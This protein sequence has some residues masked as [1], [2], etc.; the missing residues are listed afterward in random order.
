MVNFYKR[1]KS[2]LAR[3]LK[4]TVLILIV[5]WAWYVYN[6]NKVVDVKKVSQDNKEVKVFTVPD[7]LGSTEI[8]H[9]LKEEGLIKSP[10]TFQFYVWKEGIDSKLKAGEYYLSGE[11][12][13]KEIAQILTKGE[14]KTGEITLTF[15]EGWNVNEIGKYLESKGLATQDEFLDKVQQKEGWWDDYEFLRQ[16]PKDVD[17]EGYLFPD[18]YR[19]YSD[20]KV[21][22]IIRKM[23]DN[24]EVKLTQEVYQA[25]KNQGKS[26]HEIV[27]LASILEKEVSTDQDRRIVAGIFHKRLNI[28]MG[29]Q[30]DATVNYATGK[31]VTRP[32]FGDLETESPYNTYKYRGLPPGPISNPSISSIMAAIN[33]EQND[34]LY[35]LTT[36]EGEVI[37]SKTFDEHVA[38]KNKYY[39]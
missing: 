30:S 14:G 2:R 12:D 15:I 25:I 19:V 38:A 23:V 27:T 33:L 9:K 21:E 11:L 3:F 34:Y 37:Y 39:P 32:T 20:A 36:P 5:G 31:S 6:V 10:L 29:L 18:T 13:L 4:V 22:D 17:L 7:G 28:G 26:V 8:S 1:K 24:F 16:K 35:F